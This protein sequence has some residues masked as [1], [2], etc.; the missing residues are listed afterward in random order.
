M[1]DILKCMDKIMQGVYLIGSKWGDTC[2]FMTAAFVTQIS[3]NPCSLAISLDNSRFSTELI[4]KE[5]YFSVAVLAIN[6]ELE[7]KSCGYQSGR[8]VAKAKRIKHHLGD[9]GLPLVDDATA[10]LLCQVK[11][12]IAYEDHTIFIAEI[13]SGEYSDKTALFYDAE[14]FF[15]SK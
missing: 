8:T 12:T 11:Q 5:G 10:N 2:N 6:Q 3:F 13:L 7:A 15:P 1:A 14:E 9:H 4:K